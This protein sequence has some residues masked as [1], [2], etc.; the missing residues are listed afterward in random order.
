MGRER[1]QKIT[2]KFLFR[3]LGLFQIGKIQ[4]KQKKTLK[5]DSNKNYR[6]EIQ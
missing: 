4:N 2:S 6:S 1:D 5:N 3:I